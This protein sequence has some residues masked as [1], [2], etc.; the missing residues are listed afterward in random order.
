MEKSKSTTPGY[1]DCE[2][3]RSVEGPRQA[4]RPRPAKVEDRRPAAGLT[5]F[6]CRLRSRTPGPA[7]P[8]EHHELP[9]PVIF[10]IS[11]LIALRRRTS[12]PSPFSPRRG[13]TARPSILNSM[14]KN[15]VRFAN[16]CNLGCY[17]IFILPN[18]MWRTAWSRRAEARRS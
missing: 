1:C 14:K 3:N 4:R 9:V 12:G 7:P 2:R 11:P 6:R 15:W 18:N 17:I 8:P 13:R 10:A 16:E 5:F